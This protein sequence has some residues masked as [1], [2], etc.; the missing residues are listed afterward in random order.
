MIYTRICLIRY[1]LILLKD[2]LITGGYSRRGV[3]KFADIY[4]PSSNTSC[5]LPELP[6][7]RA[8]HTQDGPWACGGHGSGSSMTCDQ[9]SEGSWTRSHN[10]GLL[11]QGHVSWASASGVY[12]IG[13]EY[14]RKTS[15]LVKEDGSVEKGFKL[16]YNTR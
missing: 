3:Q 7:A 1:A 9:W 4:I 10:L 5:S 8:R 13:G 16:K 2:I 12:F 15:E 14:S 6:G 11:R